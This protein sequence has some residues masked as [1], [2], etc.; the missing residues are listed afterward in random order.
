[1]TIYNN[2]LLRALEKLVLV[3]CCIIPDGSEGTAILRNV[4]KSLNPKGQHIM[5]YDLNLWQ[6]C[7]EKSYILFIRCSVALRHV[8][9]GDRFVSVNSTYV[10]MSH[11][12]GGSVHHS[13]IYKEKS[14]KMQQ[15]IKILLYR[16]YMKLNIFRAT[17]RPSSGA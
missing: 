6:H 2:Q 9:V 13:K 14:N 11:D 15:C 7:C 3:F 17:Q 4:G 5:P 10:R 8:H 16:I 12:V 1:L